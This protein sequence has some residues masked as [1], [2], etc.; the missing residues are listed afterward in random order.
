MPVALELFIPVCYFHPTVYTTRV[1]WS[2]NRPLQLTTNALPT[3]WLSERAHVQ[4]VTEIRGG[5]GN[6]TGRREGVGGNSLAPKRPNRNSSDRNGV[7]HV[8]RC[9]FLLVESAG[10]A[11]GQDMN[12]EPQLLKTPKTG[13]FGFGTN[14]PRKPGLFRTNEP[15]KTGWFGTNEPR[16]IGWFR[17]NEPR[18]ICWFRMNEPRKTGWFGT[19]RKRLVGSERTNRERLVGSER[20]AKDWLVPNKPRKTDW[21]RTKHSKDVMAQERWWRD[22][23]YQRLYICQLYASL[24]FFFNFSVIYIISDT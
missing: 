7:C 5:G 21:F 24:L 19:N 4:A 18:K 8:S 17:M 16:K 2:D 15:R 22:I 3:C 10:E 12:H 1:S 13:W 14:E 11:G 9:N 6:E 20:T 23:G